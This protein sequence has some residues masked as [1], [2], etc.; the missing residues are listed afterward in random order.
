MPQIEKVDTGR[1]GIQ[2]YRFVREDGKVKYQSDALNGDRNNLSI[3]RRVLAVRFTSA[4]IQSSSCRLS[5][6]SHF[7]GDGWV[8][9]IVRVWIIAVTGAETGLPPFSAFAIQI[10]GENSGS[11]QAVT[12]R[13]EP[14][15]Y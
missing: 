14:C 3:S 6:G 7:N 10:L 15:Y 13:S 1:M 9:G 4:R 5:R 2:G 12:L 11:K 8:E